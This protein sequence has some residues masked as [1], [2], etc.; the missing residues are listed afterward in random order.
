MGVPYVEAEYAAAYFDDRPE[1]EAFTDLDASTRT[2]YLSY[3]GQLI[4]DYCM[5]YD[6]TGVPFTY[7]PADAPDW[8]KRA[9]C[10]EA[11]YLANLGKDPAKKLD[12]LTLGIVKTD[13]GTTFDHRFQADILGVNCR[14]ILSANGGEI[15][16]DAYVGETNTSAVHAAPVVK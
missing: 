3:A 9:V 12:V 8:L 10:E 7:D 5:F 16:A 14:R 2:K 6:E 11:L 15:A 13:D 1:C 4:A